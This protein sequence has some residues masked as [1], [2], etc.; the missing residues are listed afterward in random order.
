MLIQLLTSRASITQA[1]NRGDQ[2]EVE[3]AEAIRMI[4]AGQAVPVREAAA[5]VETAVAKANRAPAADSAPD[6]ASEA[7]V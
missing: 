4:E 7:G 1:W 6:V 5:G 2:I 3:D